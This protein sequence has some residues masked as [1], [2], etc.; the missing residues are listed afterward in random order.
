[1][2]VLVEL[3]LLMELDLVLVELVLGELDLVLVLVELKVLVG[4][5]LVLVELDLVLEELELDLGLEE[6]EVE[7]D[8]VL[9]LESGELLLVELEPDLLWAVAL[10]VELVLVSVLLVLVM[11]LLAAWW[12]SQMEQ[13]YLLRSRLLLMPELNIL[14]L[15]LPA[16]V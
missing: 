11:D 9:E 1:M 3:E 16:R 10:V 6:L 7:L 13:L 4:L 8:L 14:L 12:L 5:D 15:L 2:G